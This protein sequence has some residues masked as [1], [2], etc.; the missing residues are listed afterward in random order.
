NSASGAGTVL[1]S[2]LRG[3][4][5][6]R[7]ETGEGSAAAG[8]DVPDTLRNRALRAI[9]NTRFYPAAGQN[10]LRAM[11]ED[12]PDWVLSRQRAWG[13]PITVFVHKETGE[14][15]KDDTVN[16]RIAQAF[17]EEGADAWYKDG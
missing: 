3:E 2:P 4:V 1:T 7:S 5:G 6:S 9:D 16:H 12:R 17:E 13:V 14:I 10:R 11:M 8:A 15:L